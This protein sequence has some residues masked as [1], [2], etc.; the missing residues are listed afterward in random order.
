MRV[1]ASC[2]LVRPDAR[3]ECRRGWDMNFAF[4]RDGS[5]D[6][7]SYVTPTGTAFCIHGKDSGSY[8]THVQCARV[9]VRVNA[10]VHRIFG[11]HLAKCREKNFTGV[12]DL[13]FRL[14]GGCTFAFIC[15]YNRLCRERWP[16]SDLKKIHTW[17]T[18]I[19][20]FCTFTFTSHHFFATAT[21]D[22]SRSL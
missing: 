16:I 22:E 1:H 12:C 11:R 14:C 15:G 17:P 7:R 8:Y 3:T 18:T 21:F 4:Q 10:G 2:N 5:T 20:S 6:R 13:A 19:D 9:T